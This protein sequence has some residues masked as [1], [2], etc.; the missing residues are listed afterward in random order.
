MS[1]IPHI[2]HYC[3]FGGHPLPEEYRHYIDSWR[4]Y[5]PDFEIREW[6]ELNFHKNIGGGG[7]HTSKRHWMPLNGRLHLIMQ[8]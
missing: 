2:I 5:C 8:D 6:S 1:G 3:W 7:T 4:K